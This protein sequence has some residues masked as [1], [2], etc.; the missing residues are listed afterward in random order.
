LVLQKI[1]AGIEAA[2]TEKSPFAFPDVFTL[3]VSLPQLIMH[4]MALGS[5]T[6]MPPHKTAMKTKNSGTNYNIVFA[7]ACFR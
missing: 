2:W 7:T 6:E 5:Y 3:I 4:N 1:I